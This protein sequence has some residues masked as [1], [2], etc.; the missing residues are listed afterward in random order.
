LT[1]ENFRRLEERNVD[2]LSDE[3]DLESDGELFERKA[4]RFKPPQLPATKFPR[5]GN[6]N[7][8]PLPGPPPTPGSIITP[9][10]PSFVNHNDLQVAVGHTYVAVIEAHT[11]AFYD[12]SGNL[13]PQTTGIPTSMS[14]YTL[15]QRFLAWDTSPSSPNL[16]N[17]NRHAGFPTNPALPCDLTTDSRP[18]KSKSSCIN[19]VFD[20]RVIYEPVRKRF[21]FVAVARNQLGQCKGKP[22]TDYCGFGDPNILMLARRYYMFA[23]AKDEDPRKGFYTY[24]VGH[25]ADFPALAVTSSHLLVTRQGGQPTDPTVYMF[26]LDDIASGS[27]QPAR[28]VYFESDGV[29]W[30]TPVESQDSGTPAYFVAPS[31]KTSLQVWAAKS[32][33]APLVSKTID[34]GQEVHAIRGKIVLHSG[35]LYYTSGSAAWCKKMNPVPPDCP[36]KV[37]LVAIALNWSNNQMALSKVLDYSFGH[38]GPGDDS[39]DLVSYEFPSL[40][41]TQN[42]DVVIAYTR[43][44]IKTVKTL[45]NEARYSVFY[46]N[47]SSTRPS[48]VL[49]LGEGVATKTAYEANI[50]LTVQALDPSDGLT[51]WVTHTY[52][53]ANGGYGM[54]V[55]VVK[56]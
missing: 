25:G 28:S 4:G 38:N 33:G 9:F 10:V 8:L 50:D 56:P 55:G 22:L 14:S 39:S 40:E 43:R 54:A 44:P 34:T 19:E 17:V 29:K 41:I 24:W 5:E 15:F 48:A 7:N 31:G 37:R 42:G 21:I 16:D 51:V 35:K 26:S 53:R 3:V 1:P 6:P 11:L 27:A 45:Y 46:H 20:L 49:K 18:L 23:V 36:L 12:K 52:A 47:E 32:P 30:A 2:H 13:L